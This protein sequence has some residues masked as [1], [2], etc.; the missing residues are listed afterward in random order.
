MR[1]LP[2]DE[3]RELDVLFI[4]DTSGSY[5]DDLPNML[6]QMPSVMSMIDNDFPNQIW[7]GEL[8]HSH[9]STGS[10]GD[11]AWAVS[12]DFT[13][14]PGLVTAALAALTASGG[15][16]LPESQY[17][18]LY[19]A[20]MGTGLDLN[21]DND[22]NDLGEIAPQPLSWDSNRAPIIFLM[23]DADFHDADLEDYPS[24]T[25]QAAGRAA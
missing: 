1:P 6:A 15:S 13:S 25:G 3:T 12:Q 21:N 7:R 14:N 11:V 23:T 2:I 20:M 18:A 9:R 8:H 17:E 10:N 5:W 16:D 22:F 19:Q 24:G 4:F